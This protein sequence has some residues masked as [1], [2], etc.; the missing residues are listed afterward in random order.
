M[1]NSIK[2]SLKANL[3]LPIGERMN[4]DQRTS[5]RLGRRLNSRA[6]AVQASIA[7]ALAPILAQRQAMVSG[8]DKAEYLAS[9]AK[10]DKGANNTDTIQTHC[11]HGEAMPT[12][13]IGA[14][15]DGGNMAEANEPLIAIP[16]AYG[17]KQAQGERVAFCDVESR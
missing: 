9:Q 7:L 3:A 11:G 10:V 5:Y 16:L 4:Y 14:M 13:N 1:K 6:W 12:Y 15:R 17:D 8:A 2:N